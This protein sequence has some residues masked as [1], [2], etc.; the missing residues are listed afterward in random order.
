MGYHDAP[1]FLFILF[2]KGGEGGSMGCHNNIDIQQHFSL[3][4]LRFQAL[5]SIDVRD[6]TEEHQYCC[7]N[8]IYIPSSCS[9]I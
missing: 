5:I 3:I 4:L 2:V 6:C 7:V 8:N 9:K 1:F